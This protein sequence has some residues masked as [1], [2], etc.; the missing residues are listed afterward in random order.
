VIL[1]PPDRIDVSEA[2]DVCPRK[3]LVRHQP[4]LHCGQEGPLPRE[5]EE[6]PLELVAGRSTNPA[7]RLRVIRVRFSSDTKANGPGTQAS[8]TFRSRQHL[9]KTSERFCSG[10]SQRRSAFSTIGIGS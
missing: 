8:E 7:A 2:L 6:R 4:F 10:R 9:S 1:R 3:D 5:R